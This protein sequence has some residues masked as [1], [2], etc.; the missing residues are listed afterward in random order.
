VELSLRT[1]EHGPDDRPLVVALREQEVT[2][3]GLV[4]TGRLPASARQGSDDVRLNSGRPIYVDW[5]NNPNAPAAVLAWRDRLD[6]VEAAMADA[7]RLC[8]LVDREGFGWIAVEA[9]LAHEAGRR[10]LGDW[11]STAAGD[12]TLLIAP[13]RRSAEH[14]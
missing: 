10:C 2:G 8:R 3:E 9:E 6:E 13:G 5:K 4:P 12:L 7:G 1:I 14:D 11:T